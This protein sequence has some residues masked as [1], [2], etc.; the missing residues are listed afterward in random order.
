MTIPYPLFSSVW[1]IYFL[2]QVIQLYK[3]HAG[4]FVAHLKKLCIG[5]LD[6]IQTSIW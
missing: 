2:P 4:L 3:N 6:L 1:I 5:V